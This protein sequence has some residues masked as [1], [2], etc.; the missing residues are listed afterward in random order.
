MAQAKVDRMAITIVDGHQAPALMRVLQAAGF[1]TTQVD[2]VGGFLHEGLH[3]FLVGM[4]QSQI[5]E[6]AALVR[7]YC[8]SRT[9]YVPVGVEMTLTPAYPLMIEARL[10]GATLFILPVEQF[11]QL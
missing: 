4:E 2:A 3:T 6:F 9:R 5:A 11:L 8:P 10:G 7:R 1:K